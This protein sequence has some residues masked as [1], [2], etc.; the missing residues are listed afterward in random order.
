MTFRDDSETVAD[1]D[2]QTTAEE[3][4]DDKQLK[5]A[6]TIGTALMLINSH[7]ALFVL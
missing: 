2:M 6:A 3:R 7:R 5:K 1:S 4:D